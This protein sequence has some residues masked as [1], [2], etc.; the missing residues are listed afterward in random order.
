[1]GVQQKPQV[2]YRGVTLD[3]NVIN[4]IKFY[5]VDIVPYYEPLI[6]SSG[7]KTDKAGNEYGVYMSDNYQMSSEIYAKTNDLVGTPIDK[8][9]IIRVDGLQMM[10][11]IPSVE[12]LYKIDPTNIDV[13]R[14]WITSYLE[15]TYH[16]DEWV[17]EKVPASE[18]AVTRLTIGP[19]LLHDK[20]NVDISSIAEAEAKVK[21][22]IE[23][24]RQQLEALYSE[25]RKLPV[26]IRYQFE[27]IDLEIFKDIFGDNGV[28]YVDYDNVNLSSGIDFIKYLIR[29]NWISNSESIDFSTL[30]YIEKIKQKM[31]QGFTV[32]DLIK[33][34]RTEKDLI[35][36][37]KEKFIQRK[38]ANSESADTTN[39][40][41]RIA[42]VSQFIDKVVNKARTSNDEMHM[43]EE[44]GK[45]IDSPKSKSHRPVIS[46]AVIK[47]VILNDKKQKL[48]EMKQQLLDEQQKRQQEV[49]SNE[50]EEEE[51]DMGM[52]M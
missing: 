49:I 45:V 20:E 11:R 40:D 14:P 33:A 41:L 12:V 31:P 25:L 13:H 42:R 34:L 1:M 26:S 4:R 6:D 44:F 29:D 5:G 2:L 8:D 43:E 39:F 15:G 22:A 28:K 7:R 46:D 18:Y 21:H 48:R 47:T 27:K 38:K 16:G 9:F 35:T 19:D 37:S 51:Q 52:T 23:R 10:I 3:Y 30:R 36:A 50:E 32:D 17:A 24:R